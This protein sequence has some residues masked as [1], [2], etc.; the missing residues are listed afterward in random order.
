M[1]PQDKLHCLTS[2]LPSLSSHR[3]CFC[4][5]SMSMLFFLFS[6]FWYCPSN[7][8]SLNRK[9]VRQSK[10]LVWGIAKFTVAHNSK[11]YASIQRIEGLKRGTPHQPANRNT[12]ELVQ[13]WRV[14]YEKL[15]RVEMVFLKSIYSPEGKDRGYQCRPRDFHQKGDLSAERKAWLFA[16]RLSDCGCIYWFLWPRSVCRCYKL[17]K[18]NQTH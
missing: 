11:I 16:F 9:K 2:M 13:N 8:L 15:P 4:I 12:L 6:W 18:K 1:K 3:N 5:C 7:F 14:S 10:A 17:L